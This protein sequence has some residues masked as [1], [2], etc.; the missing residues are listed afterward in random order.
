MFR[1]MILNVGEESNKRNVDSPLKAFALKHEE[2]MGSLIS[3]IVVTTPNLLRLIAGVL[4]FYKTAPDLAG[5][6]ATCVDFFF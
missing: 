4:H 6:C 2:D 5:L 3:P 1:N